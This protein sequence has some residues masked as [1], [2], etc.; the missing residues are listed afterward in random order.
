MN[1]FS[2]IKVNSFVFSLLFIVLPLIVAMYFLLSWAHEYFIFLGNRLDVHFLIVSIGILSGVILY[3]TRL[4]GIIL[5]LIL[6]LLLQLILSFIGDFISSN[7]IDYFFHLHHLNI[8]LFLFFFA[9]LVSYS[10]I[11]TRLSS[12]IISSLLVVVTLYLLIHTNE[13]S[14]KWSFI[15]ILILFI[16]LCSVLLYSI[17]IQKK[18]EYIFTHDSISFQKT[19]G[20]SLLF[21]F[22]LIIISGLHIW[23]FESEIIDTWKKMTKEYELGTTESIEQQ[24]ENGVR[25][26][27]KSKLSGSNSRSNEL[28]L[29][30]YIDNFFEGTDFPNPL[31]L[32]AFYYSH[33]DSLT[34]TFQRVDDMPDK[35]LFTPDPT[36]IPLYFTQTD[37][38]V[39]TMVKNNQMMKTVDVEVYNRKLESYQFIAPS[40]AFSIQPIAIDKN[41]QS[42]YKNAYKSK[43]LVSELNSAYFIYNS[44]NEDVRAFQQNRIN[45]LKNVT[46]F[47]DMREDI[48][49]YYTS[50]PNLPYIN[51]IKNLAQSIT[52]NAETPIDKIIAIRDYFLSKNEKGDPLFRYSD[53]PGI[54]DLPSASKLYYFLFENRTGYCAYYAGATL[55]MLRSLKIPSRVTVGFLT[56]DRSTSNKGW[57]YFYANQL[58][59]WIQV[60]FPGYGWID[61]DT[62]VGNTEARE[63]PQP[64]GTPP[65]SPP[66][67][68]LSIYGYVHSIDTNRNTIQVSTNQLFLF[69]KSHTN[70][71][72]WIITLDVEKTQLFSFQKQISI[73]D[74]HM[75]DT[76]SVVIFNPI[77]IKE[78]NIENI[79]SKTIVPERIEIKP[80]LNKKTNDSNESTFEKPSVSKSIL[81]GISI[82]ILLLILLFILPSFILWIYKKR[83]KHLNQKIKYKYSFQ[84]LTFYLHQNGIITNF[85]KL[86]S[87]YFAEID[88]EFHTNTKAFYSDY[89]KIKFSQHKNITIIHDIES[90]IISIDKQYYSNKSFLQKLLNKINFVKA[91]RFYFNS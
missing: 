6:F 38:S 50:I 13:L 3:Y 16:S 81:I 7:E 79:D 9:C 24:G 74:I 29:V 59:A 66:K 37:S 84:A 47:E 19:Y 76:A 46:S 35:D 44:T 33:F 83:S 14:S 57:Y 45:I 67:A 31:Y 89:Q 18:H 30:A 53:N 32:T 51:D 77:S 12:I 56:H 91:L 73:H 26:N 80:F 43:S 4:R 42:E 58:H 23:F 63:S 34:E 41:F 52:V 22:L 90:M 62:T 87:H 71:T 11:N 65:T 27:D 82:F 8:K 28:L 75:N 40:T 55:L 15:R 72:P 85:N 17:F 88:K 5:I 1:L 48:Y 21:I 10:F 64:D 60:Y 61:F 68:V 86:P 78:V 54:P 36:S 70:T 25:I 69:D 20:E 49:N 39:L 2:K